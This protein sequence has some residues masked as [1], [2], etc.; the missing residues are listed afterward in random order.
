[1]A[2]PP[3]TG[4]GQ[5][6]A[7]AGGAKTPS[8]DAAPQDR[9]LDRRTFMARMGVLGAWAAAGCSATG[10]GA[11]Q[12]DGGEGWD[13]PAHGP[14][15]ARGQGGGAGV[16][17][18]PGTGVAGSS[19]GRDAAGVQA[20]LLDPAHPFWVE[21][22]REVEARGRGAVP[23]HRLAAWEARVLLED[24]RLEARDLLEA[25]LE[26]TRSLDPHLLAF[27][28]VSE[29]EARSRLSAAGNP[30]LLAGIPVAIKDNVHTAGVRTT[31][32]AHM[33]ADFVPTRDATLVKRL[34]EAGALP[35]GKTQMGP[36][37]TTRALT[38]D[39]EVTT[40]NAWA[41]DD[42]RVSPGGSS[43][44][45]A[46][47]VAARMVTTSM[48]TQT[49]GS[50]TV[51]AS[52][53]GLTGLKP[54]MGRVSLDGVI[55]LTY[56][57]DHPGPL[58]RDARDA[59]LFLQV[60]AG[61]DPR[62]PRT[63]GLPPV[64]DYLLAATPHREGGEPRM[65]WATRL[66]V[67]PGWAR[68]EGPQGD[69]RRAFVDAMERGGVQVVEVPFPPGWEA[70]TS[71]AM[72]AGR[73]PERSE[74]FLPWLREDVRLFGV[75]LSSWIQGLLL[76]SE[77][78]LTAQRGRTA[79]LRMVLEELF[80]GCDALVMTSHLPFDMVGLPLVTFPL[81]FRDAGEGAGTAGRVLPE[82]VLVGGLPFGEERLLA[83]AALWQAVS[84]HHRRVPADPRME[85][86]I[87]GRGDRGRLDVETV[88][89]LSE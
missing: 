6:A 84:D 41:P 36:L 85:A 16:G 9:T 20:R 27:N 29:A 49:G 65:R 44:G 59:A 66:G 17:T 78:Y 60:V 68:G 82:G 33:F 52:S 14:G 77:A 56:T 87:R 58:A 51:P 63:L 64:P 39:G 18:D 47:A 22:R 50:I 32:N 55:P 83:L 15:E 69:R 43:S 76:P 24:G 31:A 46:T 62:D 71:G 21:A 26:R 30:G 7:G 3:V 10:Q 2:G 79:L 25:C 53:Q 48:G 54:T 11:L 1:M 28:T 81:G 80:L 61:P 42:P 88:A 57:R 40:L 35:V 74:P 13:A 72:N 45:S 19:S 89:D 73:L 34:L 4:A 12:G 37:A 23:L 38:P 75:T 5:G 86:G 67:P 8:G 70:L